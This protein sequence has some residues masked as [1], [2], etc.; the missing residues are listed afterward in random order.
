MPETSLELIDKI[1]EKLSKNCNKTHSLEE[2]VE[3]VFPLCDYKNTSLTEIRAVEAAVLDALII[4]AD[5][6][7]IFLN[8]V[9]DESSIKLKM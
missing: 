8:L 6:N 1:L 2:L 3:A 7:L 9:T 5:S 4:L